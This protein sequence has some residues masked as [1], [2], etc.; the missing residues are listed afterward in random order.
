MNDIK[1][2]IYMYIARGIRASAV[3]E[4]NNY[5]NVNIRVSSL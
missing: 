3:N 2:G 1:N 5:N 4:S